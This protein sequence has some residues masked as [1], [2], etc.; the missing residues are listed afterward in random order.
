MGKNL[1]VGDGLE[2]GM[3]TYFSILA[4]RIFEDRGAWTAT[5]H[6]VIKSQKTESTEHP[7]LMQFFL[8][9]RLSTVER[10]G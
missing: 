4:C 8:W 5:V 2:E 10:K 9:L 7:M 6:G 1:T 3:V